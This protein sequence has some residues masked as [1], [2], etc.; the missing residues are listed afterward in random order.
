MK[1]NKNFTKIYNCILYIT[2]NILKYCTI[3][4]QNQGG[5]NPKDYDA[6]KKMKAKIFQ[7]YRQRK[8]EGEGKRQRERAKEKTTTN[9]DIS[10]QSY[11]FTRH[12]KL[13]SVK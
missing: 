7:R 3:I 1:N 4:F 11:I 9:P 2:L 12:L 5:R 10:I 6:D 8:E 13:S